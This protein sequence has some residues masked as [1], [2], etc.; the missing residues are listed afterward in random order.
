MGTFRV[1]V[2]NLLS[3]IEGLIVGGASEME[4]QTGTQVRELGSL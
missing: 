2:M 4:S 1:I 3:Y